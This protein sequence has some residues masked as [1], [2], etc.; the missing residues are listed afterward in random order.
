MFC[1]L[2]IRKII[3]GYGILKQ[4]TRKKE[5]TIHE[6]RMLHNT[7]ATVTKYSTLMAQIFENKEEK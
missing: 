1:D 2:E 4:C 3:D 7:A 5:V 6:E